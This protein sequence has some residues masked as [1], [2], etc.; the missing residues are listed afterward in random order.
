[1]LKKVQRFRIPG[2]SWGN[3]SVTGWFPQSTRNVVCSYHDFITYRRTKLLSKSAQ[4]PAEVADS[5]WMS[6]EGTVMTGHLGWQDL[7]W[8]ITIISQRF[9]AKNIN[10]VSVH[11]WRSTK[12]GTVHLFQIVGVWAVAR[13]CTRMCVC[14]TY[15][16][17]ICVT[18]KG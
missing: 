13:S 12:P 11:T 18:G 9:D 2:P 6:R 7:S 3:P 4:Q 14:E 8:Y 15:N 5:P 10:T 16:R 17:S 1:M